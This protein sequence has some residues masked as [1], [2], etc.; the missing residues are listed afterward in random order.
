MIRLLALIVALLPLGA[1]AEPLPALYAVVGVAADDELNIRL[2]P[3]ASS[4]LLGSFEHDA[5]GIEVI[6]LS[7][8]GSWGLVNDAETAGWVSMR[9]L[10]RAP[11]QGE[12]SFPAALSCAGTEPF[13]SFE[14]HADGSGRFASPV[15]PERDFAPGRRA[16]AAS[17]PD[18]FAF[19]AGGGQ[20]VMGIVTREACSDGMSERAYGFALD[21]LL[22]TPGAVLYSGCCT[23]SP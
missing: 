17:R 13:W 11:G 19:T 18:R 10:A 1:L 8:T 21:L 16:S 7:E 2:E 20:D 22:A 6:A 23:I 12:G 5:R 3:S 15:D 4:M 14:L 9:Y